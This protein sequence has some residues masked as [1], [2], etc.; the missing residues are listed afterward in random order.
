MMLSLA[1]ARWMGR[2]PVAPS[3]TRIGFAGSYP[4][5]VI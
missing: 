2:H 5:E 4:V 1:G 3:T